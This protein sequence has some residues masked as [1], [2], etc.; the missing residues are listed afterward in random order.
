M[1]SILEIKKLVLPLNFGVGESERSDLQDIEFNIIIE[2][3]SIPIA[4]SSDKIE[5]ALCYDQLVQEI[6]IFCTSKE[7]YLIEHLSFAL[8]QYI[9]NRYLGCEDKLFVQVCKFS[10]LEEIQDKCCF[11]CKG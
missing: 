5:D 11:V 1:N 6:K 2:F 3:D 7:F 9:K 4:C 8:Y 10:P